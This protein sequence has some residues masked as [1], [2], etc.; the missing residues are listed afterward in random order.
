MLNFNM[1]SAVIK[2]LLGKVKYI[3]VITMLMILSWQANEWFQNKYPYTMPEGK[4][5]LLLGESQL[6]NGFNPVW[7]EGSVNIGQFAEP[8]VL[9]YFKL[10]YI[11]QHNPNLKTVVI[12]I[13]SIHFKPRFDD[14]FGEY[15]FASE[16][17]YRSVLITDHEDFDPFKVPWNRYQEQFIRYNVI[18]NYNFFAQWGFDLFGKER[19][20]RYPFIGEYQGMNPGA[21]E[22]DYEKL[23]SEL[24]YKGNKP[25]GK[26]NAQYIDSIARITSHNNIKLVV[27]SM[28]IHK[29]LYHQVPD[30]IKQYI[31][32]LIEKAKC[33]NNVYHL[34][35]DTLYE[36][37]LFHNY[38]H[39]SHE[40]AKHL[41]VHL[42]EFLKT[43]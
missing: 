15:V 18:P 38:S 5:I 36:N 3:I 8:W 14:L 28:P 24:Y 29:G 16:F 42:N 6:A 25:C 34:P 32:T 39:L 43:L 30:S 11:L 2:Y 35:C 27:V 40:G 23:G 20:L 22:Y 21:E 4:D 1:Q 17:F 19:Q 9:S 7:I 37:H 41:S 10:R 12:P 26:T 33:Y 13:S 31:G